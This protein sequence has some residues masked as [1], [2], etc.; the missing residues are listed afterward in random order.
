M[1]VYHNIII[2]IFTSMPTA[3]ICNSV[4]TFFLVINMKIMC[5]SPV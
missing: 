5:D 3:I 4:S 2:I 1:Q